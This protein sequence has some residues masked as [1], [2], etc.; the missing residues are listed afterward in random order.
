MNKNTIT[1]EDLSQL[2]RAFEFMYDMLD[3]FPDMESDMRRKFFEITHNV[4]NL[5]NKMQRICKD[6]E[7]KLNAEKEKPAE[8]FPERFNKEFLKMHETALKFQS[9]CKKP[10]LTRIEETVNWIKEALQP[11]ESDIEFEDPRST[12]IDTEYEMHRRN[13]LHEQLTK[14]EILLQEL[15]EKWKAKELKPSITDIF[16]QMLRDRKN[17]LD[18]FNLRLLLQ[19]NGMRSRTAD[20]ELET[21]EQILETYESRI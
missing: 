15:V 8:G 9:Q 13:R 6:N 10:Q 2:Q 17:K 16:I 11:M 14:G 7:V 3:G 12:M 21:I 4:L 20:R 19:G 5:I 1:Q 18:N